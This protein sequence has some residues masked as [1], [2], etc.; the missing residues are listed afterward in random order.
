MSS[1]SFEVSLNKHYGRD[2]L[3]GAILSALRASGKNPDAIV[4]DGEDYRSFGIISA[5]PAPDTRA[6]CEP[7]AQECRAQSRRATHRAGP[8][9]FEENMIGDR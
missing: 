2:G 4:A 3:G 5:R 6:G 7:D 9:R 1:Q 8:M